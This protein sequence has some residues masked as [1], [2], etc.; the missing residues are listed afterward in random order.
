MAT[1]WK[2]AVNCIALTINGQR[3]RQRKRQ[4]RRR[5]RRRQTTTITIIPHDRRRN[6]SKSTCFS[7]FSVG[8]RLLSGEHT[9]CRRRE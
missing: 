7:Y 9:A 4:R 5:L 6:N 2:T 1:S 3:K 8:D